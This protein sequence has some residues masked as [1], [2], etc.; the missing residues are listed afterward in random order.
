MI[1]KLAWTILLVLNPFF[2]QKESCYIVFS[3]I[4]N[5]VK[6]YSDNKLVYESGV[7]DGNPK[8]N[9]TVNLDKFLKKGKNTLK[10]ELHNGSGEGFLEHDEHWEIYY[11][12]FQNEKPI[13]YMFESSNNGKSGLVFTME[14][15]IIVN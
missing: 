2:Q 13:D 10:V 9:I 8:L 1:Q 3:K 12:I 4:D 5:Q 11:E 7:I 15:E 14:H 6:V